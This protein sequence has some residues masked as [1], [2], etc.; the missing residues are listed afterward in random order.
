M[1]K[2]IFFL[3]LVIIHCS[4]G[5][6]KDTA[7][8]SDATAAINVINAIPDADININFGQEIINYS[9]SRKLNYYNWDGK[10]SNGSLTFGVPVAKP[11]PLTIVLASDTTKAIF[12]EALS[13]NS[14]DV[15]SLFIGG[16][17]FSTKYI[18]VKDSL[19][20]ITDSLT[21]VRFVNMCQDMSK[22]SI[23]ISG[24][25]EGSE[26]PEL[27]FGQAS[28]FI[29]YPAKSVDVTYSFEFHDVSTGNLLWT[30]NYN[31]S[32]FKYVTLILRGLKDAFP[33]IEVV[34]MNNS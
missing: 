5:C 16:K 4:T 1:N 31:V 23:N 14:G 27:N 19:G 30:F 7:D 32:R 3:C 18:L 8:V 28:A 11:L 26:I 21:G 20:A 6:N 25:T 10:N 2:Y 17:P 24:T 9:E 29:Y 34:R 13:C 15:Y 22:V 12:S 33:E